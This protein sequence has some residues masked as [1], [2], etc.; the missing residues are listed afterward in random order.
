MSEPVIEPATKV[1]K[2][3]SGIIDRALRHGTPTIIT[4][5]GRSEAVLP[6]IDEYHH[7]RETAEQYEDEWLNGLADQAESEGTEGSVPMEQM[8]ALLRSAN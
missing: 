2:H 6:S 8:A 3:L 5:R 1:R 7:L 4:R